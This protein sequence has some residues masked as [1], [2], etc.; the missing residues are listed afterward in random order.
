VSA[1]TAGMA[2]AAGALPQLN[3]S[4]QFWK[5]GL[6]GRDDCLD[7]LAFRPHLQQCLFEIQVER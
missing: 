2:V 5:N 7:S 6:K 3:R 4:P 1:G